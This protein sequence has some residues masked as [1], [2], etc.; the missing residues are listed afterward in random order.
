[1]IEAIAEQ[2]KPLPTQFTRE[3]LQVKFLSDSEKNAPKY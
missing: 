3:E 1:M 2:H